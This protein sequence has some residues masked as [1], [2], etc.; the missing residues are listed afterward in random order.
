MLVI[1]SFFSLIVTFFYFNS[2]LIEN[3]TI[4]NIL[5]N[6]CQFREEYKHQCLG[7]FIDLNN[8]DPSMFYRPPLRK[9]PD[10][11]LAE[12]TQQGDMPITKD[13]YFNDVYSDANT[14][15]TKKLE[16]INKNKVDYY[17]LNKNNTRINNYYFDM[18]NHRLMAKYSNSIKNKIMTIIGTIEPWLEAIA[19]DAG[20]GKVVTLGK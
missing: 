14:N 17:R 6:Y 4:N 12:F 7:L 11:L 13:W 10:N 16:I 18:Q 3:K 15:L 19:L 5:E 20:A 2:N 1:L 9:V 8:P